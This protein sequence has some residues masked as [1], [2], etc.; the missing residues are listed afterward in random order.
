MLPP[1]WEVYHVKASFVRVVG[2]NLHHNVILVVYSSIKFWYAI[3]CSSGQDVP[4]K[5]VLFG[6]FISPGWEY[7]VLPEP[8]PASYRGIVMGLVG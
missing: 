6:I 4:S 8:L 3:K 1:G 2:K 7:S 5:V